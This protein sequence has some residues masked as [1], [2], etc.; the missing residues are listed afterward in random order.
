MHNT[1]SR[2][3]TALVTALVLATSA[4][5][6]PA[7]ARLPVSLET[8]SLAVRPEYERAL[9]RIYLSI[10]DEYGDQKTPAER[11]AY[12]GFIQ[13]AYSELIDVLPRY[14]KIDVAVSTTT[15][16]GALAN[17]KAV[18]GERPLTFHVLDGLHSGIDMWAQDIGE[19]IRV[20]GRDRFLVPMA[21]ENDDQ[22]NTELSRSRGL[23]ARDVFGD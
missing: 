4:V 14:T 16:A 15:D 9:K 20:V 3:V 2:L 22:Y 19:R 8:L 6:L 10:P 23:V 5:T 17:L 1:S 7:A 11:A 13:H 12:L 18:A 21:V